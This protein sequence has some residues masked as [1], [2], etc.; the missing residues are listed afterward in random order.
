MNEFN[1]LLVSPRWTKSENEGQ[2]F[3]L[4]LPSISSPMKLIGLNVFTLNLDLYNEKIEPILASYIKKHNISAVGTTGFCKDYLIV[5]GILSAVKSINKDIITIVGGPILSGDPVTTMEVLDNVDFGVIGEGEVTVCELSLYLETLYTGKKRV[6]EF[7]NKISD[8]VLGGDRICEFHKLIKHIEH[9]SDIKGVI[10]RDEE[11]LH[12]TPARP[13][14]ESL[15]VLPWVDYEG[16]GFAEYLDRQSSIKMYYDPVNHFHKRSLPISS[17]RSCPNKCTFCFHSLGRSYRVRDTNDFMN[18]VEYMI[19]HYDIEFVCIVDDLFTH[20]INHVEVFSRAMEKYDMKWSIYTRVT[21][22]TDKLA[23]LLSNSNCQG[24]CL[25]IESASNQILKSMKK[26]ITVEKT[27]QA[28]EILCKHNIR[29]LGNIIIGDINETFETAQ[30][31][32]RWAKYINKRYKQLHVTTIFLLAF[33][34]SE[35]YKY[36]CE[37][38]FITDRM[39]FFKKSIPQINISK[40]NNGEFSKISKMITACN[41]NAH[42]TATCKVSSLNHE[43]HNVDVTVKCPH[44][45]ATKELY[46]CSLALFN[47][48]NVIACDNCTSFFTLSLPVEVQQTIIKNIQNFL[49]KGNKVAF[50][51]GSSN[52]YN[53]IREHD[54]FKQD[55]MYY[56]DGYASN[57]GSEICAEK[58][59]L[60]PQVLNEEKVEIVIILALNYKK[61]IGETIRSNYASVKKIFP[62]NQLMFKNLK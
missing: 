58:V 41:E 21:F 3:P 33:P 57:H 24:V 52:V 23:E 12:Q 61:I 43:A 42:V 8:G 37:N 60:S 14:I 36:A 34:G 48:L 9:V 4:A 50:W 22:V 15:D 17:S 10:Y 45:G 7:N 39:E 40:M 20:K 26:K 25:G 5:D 2:P 47:S 28:I 51:G 38:K 19:K 56:V 11:G 35:V 59:V 62:I 27:E 55:C 31:S 30:V 54:M 13:P 49:E 16:F 1:I 29:T 32:L 46:S 44:C 6:L 18:N 53:L